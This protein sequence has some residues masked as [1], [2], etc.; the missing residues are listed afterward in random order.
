M[1]IVNGA[2][3]HG[4]RAAL[5]R[6][7]QLLASFAVA[8]TVA[9]TVTSAAQQCCCTKP[10]DSPCKEQ[11]RPAGNQPTALREID[12]RIADGDV[13]DPGKILREQP[14][15]RDL[16]RIEQSVPRR[17]IQMVGQDALDIV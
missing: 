14:V 2:S 12:E 9:L 16:K 1:P 8:L 13:A 4:D 11:E 15:P 5:R 6:G 3:V 7:Q 17:Q 10:A